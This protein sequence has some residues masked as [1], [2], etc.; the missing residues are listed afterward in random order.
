M[1]VHFSAAVLKKLASVFEMRVNG[2]S[3]AGGR[4]LDHRSQAGS[5]VRS[6]LMKHEN[7]KDIAKDHSR[8]DHPDAGEGQKPA[9]TQ[10]QKLRSILWRSN[11][12][13]GCSHVGYPESGQ[14]LER[15]AILPEKPA[16]TTSLIF[17]RTNLT[18]KFKI[19]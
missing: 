2:G 5:N 19:E 18:L 1:R 11:Q 10:R 12:R 14:N 7:G 8:Q 17:S 9:R 6:I 15:R 3:V 13:S 16:R 4:R